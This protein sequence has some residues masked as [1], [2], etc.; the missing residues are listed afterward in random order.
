MKKAKTPPRAHTPH[1]HWYILVCSGCETLT[2]VR[3]PFQ[4]EAKA[5]SKELRRDCI[6][7][8]FERIPAVKAYAMLRA[9]APCKPYGEIRR[10][11]SKALSYVRGGVAL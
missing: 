4:A 5:Y 6:V 2:A 1:K 7:L 3:K 10:S 11:I 9:F 8:R